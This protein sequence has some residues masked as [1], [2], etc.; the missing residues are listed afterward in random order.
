MRYEAFVPQCGVEM[1]ILCFLKRHI[2]LRPSLPVVPLSSFVLQGW[3][4]VE[5]LGLL[6]SRVSLDGS[7]FEYAGPQGSV[8][9]RKGRSNKAVVHG[10]EK[11]SGI[12]ITRDHGAR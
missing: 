8:S 2:L 10:L 12:K 7:A 5:G 9:S 1:T 6:R 4:R 11:E 3:V